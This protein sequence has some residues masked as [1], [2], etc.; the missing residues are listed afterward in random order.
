M[1]RKGTAGKAMDLRSMA[2]SLVVG[3]WDSPPTHLREGAA[4]SNGKLLPSPAALVGRY[5]H[6]GVAALRH[7]HLARLLA[8]GGEVLAGLHHHE[9]D[10]VA[11]GSG[12]HPHRGLSRAR[13]DAL[14]GGGARSVPRGVLPA[15]V[16]PRDHLGG[17]VLLGRVPIEPRDAHR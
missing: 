4:P 12:R 9:P 17:E 6:G 11:T 10:R 5:P 7:L 13:G 14:A 8:H 3:P 16:V 15:R 1:A 2:L